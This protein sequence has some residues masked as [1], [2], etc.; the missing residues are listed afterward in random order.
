[1]AAAAGLRD[2]RFLTALRGRGRRASQ[3]AADRKR[4]RWAAAARLHSAASHRRLARSTT[5]SNRC[6]LHA[7]FVATLSR[8]A[9]PPPP[10]HPYL[11]VSTCVCEAVSFQQHLLSKA[12]SEGEVCV[13]AQVATPAAVGALAPAETSPLDETD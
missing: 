7:S 4:R 6:A 11:C 2:H 8:H 10:P 12:T 5:R 13:P 1:M 3:P 9:L